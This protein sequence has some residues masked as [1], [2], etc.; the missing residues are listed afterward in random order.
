ME[1]D[2][3]FSPVIGSSTMTMLQLTMHSLSSSFWPENQLL[4]WNIHHIPLIWLQ[5]TFGSF[6]KESLP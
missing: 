6:Q 3:N 2:L 1:K 5:I 4:E